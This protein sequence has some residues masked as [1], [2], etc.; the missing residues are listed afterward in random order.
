M[1]KKYV[2]FE[3]AKLL[4][5][6]GFDVV[7][8]LKIDDENPLNLNS[9][10]NPREYQPW[11]LDLPQ[12][13]VAEWLLEKHRI[14]INVGYSGDETVYMMTTNI[15]GDVLWNEKGFNTPQE[16]YSAAFDYILKQLI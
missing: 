2:T 5:E 4:Q 8:Y 15:K 16:A 12:H 13:E 3:Q 9:N 7:E 11:Y 6:K 10:Y 1:K 14:W